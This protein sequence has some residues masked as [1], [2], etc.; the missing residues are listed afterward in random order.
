MGSKLQ[1][2]ERESIAGALIR[3][4]QRDNKWRPVEKDEFIEALSFTGLVAG[5]ATGLSIEHYIVTLHQMIKEGLIYQGFNG[6]ERN[7][8]TVFWKVT[9]KLLELLITSIYSGGAKYDN[10]EKLLERLKH[11]NEL[12]S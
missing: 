6:K 2:H 8:S 1:N 3:V 11:T 10:K 4:C 7:D 5:L 12:Y 9:P